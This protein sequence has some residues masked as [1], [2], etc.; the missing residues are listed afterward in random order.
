TA[1]LCLRLFQFGKVIWIRSHREYCIEL[2][3]SILRAADCLISLHQ[4]QAQE[5][6]ARAKLQSLFQFLN[7][8]LRIAAGNPWGFQI[9][10]SQDHVGAAILV[11]LVNLED[12]LHFLAQV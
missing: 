7:C 4:M 3:A 10:Y 11:A 6:V 8:T 5:S 2:L 1:S 12:R 9:E